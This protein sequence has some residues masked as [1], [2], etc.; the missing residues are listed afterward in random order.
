MYC[1]SK[2]T[3]FHIK[4]GNDRAPENDIVPESEM[5]QTRHRQRLPYAKV[6]QQTFDPTLASK[7]GRWVHR[8]HTSNVTYVRYVSSPSLCQGSGL[9]RLETSQS[10]KGQRFPI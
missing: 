3:G 10:K 2:A 5:D 7:R 6:A 4:A 8:T 1:M 9:Q